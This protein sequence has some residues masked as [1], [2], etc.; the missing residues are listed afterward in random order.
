[1]P[2][3]AV[4][5]GIEEGLT[6]Q[7]K[8]LPAS[9]LYD[10]VGSAL[11]E[12]ITLLPE[13]GLTRA[14]AALLARHSREIVREA[15]N[16]D[17]ITE[18]GSGTGI[19]TRHILEAA[20]PARYFPVD[21]SRSALQSC[22]GVLEGI[23]GIRVHPVEASY[24]DGIDTVLASRQNEPVLVLFLGST[25][26]NFDRVESG[27]FLQEIRRRLQPGDCLL[28][29]TDLV[30]PR[31]KLLSAYDDEAGVTAAFNLNLL[32]HINREL[33]GDF[34]LRNFTHEARYDE[35]HSRV[36]M[37]LR[38]KVA[39]TVRIEALGLTI[40]LACGETIWTESSHKFEPEGIRETG[41]DA[42]FSVVRQ[43]LDHDWGFAETLFEIE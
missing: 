42:G 27:S 18:L 25:I 43:W 2:A 20:A 6:A 15:G 35:R 41:R 37:H 39:Q 11:F 36:E 1:M 23:H 14:E 40:S 22:E 4:L 17:L 31:A 29:G 10:D 33:G 21:I 30:K 24:M 7:R 9:W 12:V 16:P 28:L 13:Y 3:L 26:G 34:I 8:T 38:S 5:P 32:A 19:K